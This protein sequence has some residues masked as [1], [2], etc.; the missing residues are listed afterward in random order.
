[1]PPI[2]RVVI[3]FLLGA[4]ASCASTSDDE[5]PDPAGRCARV[6]DHLVELQVASAP[7]VDQGAHRDALAA[8]LGA[9]FGERCQDAL[10]DDQ[11]DC[12]LRAADATSAATCTAGG[13]P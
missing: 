10:T 4:A 11:L 1:M 9:D 3:A 5:P 13:A 8:A 2:H 7:A 6:R 12:V